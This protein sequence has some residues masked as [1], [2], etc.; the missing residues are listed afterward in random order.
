MDDLILHR[1]LA[2]LPTKGQELLLEVKERMVKRDA[3]DFADFIEGEVKGIARLR[4][5]VIP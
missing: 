1:D 5:D 3:C 2:D 4:C